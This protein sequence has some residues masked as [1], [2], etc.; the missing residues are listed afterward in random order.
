MVN[1]TNQVEIC[2]KLELNDRTFN[3]PIRTFLE[4]PDGKLI[5]VSVNSYGANILVETQGVKKVYYIGKSYSDPNN[6]YD[7]GVL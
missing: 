4:I 2:G 5:D 1:L 3:S 6:Y 7:I